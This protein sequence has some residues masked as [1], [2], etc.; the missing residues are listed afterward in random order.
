MNIITWI[1]LGLVAGV[2]AKFIMP[3]RDP[4]GIIVTILLGVAGAFLGGFIA[5]RVGW[6]DLTGF[7]FRSVLIAIGGA[8]LLLLA[9]RLLRRGPSAA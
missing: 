8:L 1:L 7:D 5:T 2:L 9:Y 3:G 4:G 6:G